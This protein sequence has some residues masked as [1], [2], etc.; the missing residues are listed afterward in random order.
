MEQDCREELADRIAEM[1]GDRESKAIILGA[2]SEF[3][4]VR[5]ERGLIVYEG[6][7]TEYLIKRF[8]VAKKVSGRTEK[9]C[10]HYAQTLKRCFDKIRKSPT[11]CSHID[12]QALIAG[13]ILNGASKEYQVNVVRTLSSFYAW[14][15]KEDIVDNNIMLKIEPIKYKWK[16]KDAFTD[17]DVEKIR[18]ACLTKRESA[19]V[20]FLLST[21]CRVFETGKI[22]ISEIRGDEISVIG[23]GEK[24]R[25]V[26]LN[27]KAMLAIDLYLKE[28]KDENP[29]LFPSSIQD[30]ESVAHSKI[31]TAT[32]EWYKNKNLVSE[33]GFAGNSQ[34]E[35]IIKKIGKRA[36]VENCHPH[37]FRRTC[38]TMALRRGMNIVHVQQMLGHESL[39][40]T[41]RYLDISQ[42]ELMEAHRKFV[43]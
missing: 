20:E 1:L 25:K 28:R 23:K 30:G 7:Q 15:K 26:Y 41:R 18:N 13:M 33:N 10:K 35:Q 16:K 38:A 19:L 4:I 14:M 40:T 36:G 39:E 27:A 34:I 21:G 9:T 31:R 42:E 32:R 3:D 17:M 12:I 37:R 6:G 22:K 24:L 5:K 11:E 8:A 29:Y 2:M 43:I